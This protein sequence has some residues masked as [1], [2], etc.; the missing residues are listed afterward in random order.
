[1]NRRILAIGIAVLALIAVGVF[2]YL[3]S[4]S[5]EVPMN[6]RAKI[7]SS[8]GGMNCYTYEEKVTVSRGNSSV[9]ST[10]NGGHFNDTYFFHGKREGIEW[11]TVVTKRAMV[12]KVIVNGTER[13]V[14]MNLSEDEYSMLISYDPVKFSQGSG[15]WDGSRGWK[16]RQNLQIHNK[17]N[18]PQH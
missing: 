13:T 11:W 1:M 8:L 4:S 17:A 6:Y 7:L 12:Q 18:I 9:T 3:G 15:V 2:Y 14:K 10:I 16:I 5:S